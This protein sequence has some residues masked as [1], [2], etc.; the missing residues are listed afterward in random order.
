[1]LWTLANR[2]VVDDSAL[3]ICTTHSHTGINAFQ[4]LASKVG[5]TITVDYTLW[6]AIGRGIDV[7]HLTGAHANSIHHSLLAVQTTGI[8]VTGIRFN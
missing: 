3:R 5:W 2:I 1:M 7:S 4:L 8:G 6:A